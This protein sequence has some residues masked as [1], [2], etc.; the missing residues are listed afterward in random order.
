MIY[1]MKAVVMTGKGDSSVLVIDK[2]APPSIG[3]EDLMVR[4]KATALN[5]ADLLQRKGTYPA[6]L[7]TR[8]DIP[9][10]EFAGVVA[11]VG[12]R[13]GAYIEGDRVMGLLPGEAHA[14]FVAAPAAT[15]LRIPEKLT[16]EEAAAIPEAFL[17]AH[18]ALSQLELKIGEGVL[19]HAVGSGVGTAALQ[20]AGALGALTF[21]T[22]TSELKLT[23][24][25]ELGLK[26]GINTRKSNF[27]DQ[28]EEAT[29]GKGVEAL[30]DL[31][32]ASNWASNLRCLATKGRMLLVGLVGGSRVEADLSIIL[33]KRLRIMGTVLRS[34]NLEEK[35]KLVRSFRGECLP[36]FEEGTIR[37]VI[38]SLFPIEEVARA[39]EHMEQNKNFGKIVLA[40]FR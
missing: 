13:A 11:S 19:I 26:C 1:R 5:R 3:P 40:G 25:Q 36:L 4:V 31:V 32:G 17:T 6:P 35:T 24:A 37:P 28:I 7:G 9:G 16:F 14:E 23:R 39:H 12:T 18:D 20:L 8:Q 10:L 29:R 30:L 27:Y 21:G 2:V 38:D 15:V 33:R 22:S 34:R